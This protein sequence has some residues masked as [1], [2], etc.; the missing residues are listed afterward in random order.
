MT[1][2]LRE[3]SAGNAA[4]VH[5]L[6]PGGGLRDDLRDD[7]GAALHLL[8]G[9]VHEICGPARRSLAAMI[10][11]ADRGSG[12]MNRGPGN[13]GPTNR[14]SENWGPTNWGPVIWIAAGWQGERLL[15]DGLRDFAEPGRVIFVTARHA[16]DLLWA[17]EEALRSG[18][19]PLVI[20]D[21]PEPPALTPVRRLQLATEAG[22]RVAPQA[23]LGLM[24]TPG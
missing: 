9:R 10:M 2:L 11:G 14:R 16:P 21:L 6:L 17:M 20:A 18:A 3:S 12:P 22:A 7:P 24:L 4:H 15:P 5:P 23:P 13:W 19:A 8:R 1:G